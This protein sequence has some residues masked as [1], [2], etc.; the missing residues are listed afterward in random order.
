MR[1]AFGRICQ[2]SLDKWVIC[3]I[4]FPRVS[5]MLITNAAWQSVHVMT[6]SELNHRYV[7]LNMSLNIQKYRCL[8]F[9]PFLAGSLGETDLQPT[10]HSNLITVGFIRL[11]Q[12][13]NS[14][15]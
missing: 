9:L 4:T 1:C 8:R 15:L 7:K 6:E 10:F 11:S 14:V 2:D 3:H 5:V 12:Y 13:R